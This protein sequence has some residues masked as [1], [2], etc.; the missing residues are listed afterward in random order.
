V[1]VRSSSA[2]DAF[3]LRAVATADAADTFDPVGFGGQQGYYH[4]YAG[5]SLLT[6]RYYDAGAGRFVTRDPLGYQGGINLYGFAGNNPVNMSDP[7]GYAPTLGQP[8]PD[9]LEKGM[10]R[11]WEKLAPG[12]A[13]QLIR[14]AGTG[15]RM[16]GGTA[17]ATAAL[18]F[19]AQTRVADSSTGPGS[20]YYKM[21]TPSGGGKE[22][23]LSPAQMDRL[24]IL[25]KL[26]RSKGWTR[27]DTAGGVEQWGSM[28]A[29][30][31][32]TWMLKIKTMNSAADRPELGSGS[33]GPR[34]DYRYR[35]DR[36]D[37]NKAYYMD[38]FTGATGKGAGTHIPL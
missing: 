33:T 26:A 17:A 16:V 13:R 23:S 4:D 10:E 15:L 19:M 20:S 28:D 22:G 21:H 18:F 9:P 31:N 35:I 37:N 3:S 34:F 25:R 30:G 8:I 11:V 24:R 32:Y 2:Y 27:R 6:H 1:K 38:P 14:P 7:S 36:A 5:L 12:I 29:D